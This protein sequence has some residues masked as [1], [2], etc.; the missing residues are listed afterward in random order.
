L[1]PFVKLNIVILALMRYKISG[2]RGWGEGSRGDG[3][4]GS[5]GEGRRINKYFCLLPLASCL[6]KLITVNSNLITGN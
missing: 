1:H 6:Q 2:L 3:E 5:G 4:V